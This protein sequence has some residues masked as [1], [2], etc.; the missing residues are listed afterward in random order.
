MKARLAK[1]THNINVAGDGSCQG[2]YPAETLGIAT[3]CTY[4]SR[5]LFF[6]PGKST[7]YGGCCG[8]ELS[9]VEYLSDSV[10]VPEPPPKPRWTSCCEGTCFSGSTGADAAQLWVDTTMELL[11]AATTASQ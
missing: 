3:A 2:L 8:T 1:L 4:S 7:Y 11:T 9:S 6:Y 10:D 5:H